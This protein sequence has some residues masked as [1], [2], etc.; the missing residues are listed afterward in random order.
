MPM[1]NILEHIFST[2]H[3]EILRISLNLKK[4]LVWYC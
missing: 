4:M 3:T 1:K 2:L